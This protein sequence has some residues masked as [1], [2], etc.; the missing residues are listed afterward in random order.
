MPTLKKTKSFSVS[1]NTIEV[2]FKGTICECANLLKSGI[3][4]QT[5]V[6]VAY[7][8][9]WHE[10][11]VL[12]IGGDNSDLT[13]FKNFI[14]QMGLSIVDLG[15][16]KEEIKT[17]YSMKNQDF[18]DLSA[19]FP[20]Y[21]YLEISKLNDYEQKS[22]G[23][24]GIYHLKETLKH[25]TVKKI[26][27]NDYIEK[28]EKNKL[29]IIQ[30]M[31]AKTENIEVVDF[32]NVTE[33]VTVSETAEV[34]VT[35]P[36]TTET[37]A[38]NKKQISIQVFETLTPERISEIQGLNEA[39]LKIVKENPVV[40]ITDKETYEAAKKTRAILL[41]ASTSIDGKDGV[42]Q[43]A[44]RYINTFKTM[45][46]NALL[47]I[48]KLT[49]DPY[50]EQNEIISAWENAEELK[51][52]TAERE[53]LL[54]IKQRTDLLFAVP[55]TFN[56]TIYSIGNIVVLP[57]QIEALEDE[58]FNVLV[59]NGKKVKISI[60]KE[61]EAQSQKD[62]EIEELKRKLA[63]L[64]GLAN[65]D[66]SVAE[67]VAVA[68]SHPAATST[69]PVATENT[70]TV[71]PSNDSAVNMDTY[72]LPNPNNTLLNKLDLEHAEHLEKPAYIKCRNYYIRGLNEV[73]VLL[74]DIL[75]DTD[76]TVKKSVK[77]AELAKI[78][79]D[80]K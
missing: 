9:K 76:V 77:I 14:E 63:M 49:R 75:I 28:T 64:E 2:N 71:N 1:E 31:K 48:A 80:S 59:E 74:N 78:L 42:E 8:D 36:T 58:D 4:N 6:L 61:I 30:E 3:Q 66:T 23:R 16:A 32:E 24:S 41:K 38:P 56:G 10:I 53:R 37:A 5:I 15:I 17:D 72:T 60:D 67:P 62:A 54:K 21:Y 65:T 20:D 43:T 55:F 52:Q 39:Q 46:K 26:T 19:L 18:E 51:K 27:V 22:V 11:N 45:L 57:S 12:D 68:A 40:K 44:T 73:G 69:Q 29:K 34:I 79:M 13:N 50:N 33:N 25:L 70:K 35:E 7:S 47:P